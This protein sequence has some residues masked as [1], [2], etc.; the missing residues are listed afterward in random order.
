MNRD[1]RKRKTV[2]DRIGMREWKEH[3]MRL[4]GEVEHRVRER[5]GRR[6][7]DEEEEISR[8]EIKIAIRKIKY[9]GEEVTDWT[10]EFCNRIWK[11]EKWPEDWKEGVIIP[12]AKKGKGKKVEEYRGVTLMTTMY[13]VYAM[14]LAERL[15][16]ECEEKKVIPQNQTGFRKGMGTMDNIFVVNYLINRQLGKRK[17]A[18]ALFVNLKAAF[19]S[20]DRGIMYKAMRERGIRDGLIERIREVLRET[21]SRVKV[22]GVRRKFLD[23]KRIK[24]RMPDEPDA[25]QHNDCGSGRRDEES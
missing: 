13:K 15:R 25:I 12:I 18:V 3:F 20:V 19:D 2:D 8:E 1:R 11:E 5:G 16:I 23:S 4:L 9:G 17:K 6:R 10:G 24:T 7:E 21:K 14:V 22:G